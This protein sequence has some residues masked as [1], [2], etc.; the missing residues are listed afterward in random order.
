MLADKHFPEAYVSLKGF[1]LTEWVPFAPGRYYTSQ[2]IHDREFALQFVSRERDE[3]TPNG[4]ISMV[5]GGIGTI[6]L[7]GKELAGH[8][9]YFLGASSSGITHQGIPIALTSDD[10]RK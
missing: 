6:R 8:A 1:A 3:Y 2:A 4:K 7:A 9:T 10:Y 5:R